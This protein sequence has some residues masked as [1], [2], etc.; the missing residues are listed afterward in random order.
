MNAGLPGSKASLNMN[1]CEKYHV[2]AI[3]S[4]SSKIWKY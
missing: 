2:M 1:N 4:S 3:F